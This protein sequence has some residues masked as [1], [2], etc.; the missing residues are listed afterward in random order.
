MLLLLHQSRRRRMPNLCVWL[1]V[2]G[3]CVCVCVCVRLCVCARVCVCSRRHACGYQCIPH[4]LRGAGSLNRHSI[5]PC[6]AATLIATATTRPTLYTSLRQFLHTHTLSLSLSL[7]HTHTKNETRAH[8]HTH[9]R[10]PKFQNYSG[11]N[12]LH[13]GSPHTDYYDKQKVAGPP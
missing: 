5:K 12:A 10:T 13:A 7:A 9:T 1:C 2:C 6:C 8:T 3:V 4:A 11:Y